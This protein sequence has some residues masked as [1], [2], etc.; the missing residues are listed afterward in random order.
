MTSTEGYCSSL[1]SEEDAPVVHRSVRAVRDHILKI[2]CT[3]AGTV[4]RQ[5]VGKARGIVTIVDTNPACLFVLPDELDIEELRREDWI[6]TSALAQS[7]RPLRVT[8]LISVRIIAC[9][10]V[11]DALFSS[12]RYEGHAQSRLFVAKPDQILELSLPRCYRDDIVQRWVF[13]EAFEVACDTGVFDEFLGPGEELSGC[14]PK[15]LDGVVGC[16]EE[17]SLSR[18]FERIA[19][20]TDVTRCLSRYAMCKG[21]AGQDLQA[22]RDY[23]YERNLVCAE[24]Q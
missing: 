16:G 17:E 23:L 15:V 5:G 20:L 21:R 12:Q 24:A 22:K 7:D 4:A 10:K 11:R 8:H 9:H 13:K 3:T 6:S 18:E 19:W 1:A 2:C 14:L